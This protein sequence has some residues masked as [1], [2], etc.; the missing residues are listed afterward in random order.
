MRGSHTWQVKTRLFSRVA[1]TEA[2]CAE[3][4]LGDE[5]VSPADVVMDRAFSLAEPPDVVWPWIEQLGKRRAGWYFP[6]KVE[7]L[8]PPRR[9][10]LRRLDPAFLG[11]AVGSVIPDYG[12]RDETFEV[13]RIDRPNHL[14]YRSQRGRTSVSWA[15]DL[16]AEQGGTRVVLRLR[17]GPVKR[18]W[19]A[20]SL[21]ELIDLL[22]IAGLAAGLAERLTDN[23]QQ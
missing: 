7:R 6:R 12:G 20:K 11:L 2:E 21:G 19:L 4:R 22:T 16:R 3:P 17:L 13:A 15:I 9:R 14:V 18:I 5:L 10:G 23:P 8:V 1:A